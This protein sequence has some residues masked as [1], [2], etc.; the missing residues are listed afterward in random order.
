MRC[1]AHTAGLAVRASVRLLCATSESWRMV[2][3]SLQFPIRTPVGCRRHKR[4]DGTLVSPGETT[5]RFPLEESM[6]KSNGVNGA[7]SAARAST[8][9]WTRPGTPAVCAH[10]SPLRH[11]SRRRECPT[12]RKIRQDHPLPIQIRCICK[13]RSEPRLGSASLERGSSWARHGG[14][15]RKGRSDETW[16]RARAQMK[17]PDWF[18]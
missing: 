8:C 3:L 13:G 16:R 6:A 15:P 11:M 17:P 12:P 5:R 1:V 7:R 14:Q 18:T 10:R 4:C 2:W 9:D